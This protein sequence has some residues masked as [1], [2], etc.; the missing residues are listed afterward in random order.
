ME[1]SLIIISKK[2]DN[3]LINTIDNWIYQDYKDKEIIVIT[4]DSKPI[5][6]KIKIIKDPKKG[7]SIA[8]NLGLKNAK[9]NY[10]MFIDSDEFSLKKD[11]KKLISYAMKII[12][13]ENA[14]TGYFLSYPVKTGNFL[15]NIINIKDSLIT[16]NTKRV[17]PGII[18][19]EIIKKGFNENLEYGEDKDFFLRIKKSSKKS[20]FINMPL[21]NDSSISTFNLFFNRYKWYGET[22]NKYIKQT[23]DYSVLVIVIASLLFIFSLLLSFKFK[24]FL[25]YNLLFLMYY[26]LKKGNMIIYCIKKEMFFEFLMYPFINI[27]SQIII[28]I[29][30][31]RGKK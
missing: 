17:W 23:K 22:I 11:D 15:R 27:I 18:K 31:L 24:Y 9:G 26:Y 6:R 30:I 4:P 21:M 12:K 5:D 7:P 10:I 28:L 29:F 19:K 13:K 14:D 3:G 1:L 25:I 2:I 16:N 20:A 8:R